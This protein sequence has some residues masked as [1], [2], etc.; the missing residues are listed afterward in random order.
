VTINDPPVVPVVIEEPVG[1]PPKAV[2]LPPPLEVKM[3]VPSVFRPWLSVNNTVT[4]VVAPLPIGLL[5]K[6]M[7]RLATGPAELPK[8]VVVPLDKL[9]SLLEPSEEQPDKNKKLKR[10]R[11]NRES[12]TDGLKRRALVPTGDIFVLPFPAGFVITT[13]GIKVILS[14]GPGVLVDIRFSPRVQGNPFLQIG[15]LPFF[16]PRTGH[17]SV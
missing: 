2:K 7:K 11:P 13:I 15:A 10:I 6:L 17:Q 9:L 5:P 16:N 1:V 3:T 14:V 12:K 4:V 8:P